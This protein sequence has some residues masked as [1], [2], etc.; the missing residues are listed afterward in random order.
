M[1]DF[2]KMVL[3]YFNWNMKEGFQMLFLVHIM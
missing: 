2:V 3:I 1:G